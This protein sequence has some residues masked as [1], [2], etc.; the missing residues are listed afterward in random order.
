MSDGAVLFTDVVGAGLGVEIAEAIG[1]VLVA[2][3]DTVGRLADGIM[4]FAEAVAETFAGMVTASFVCTALD[5]ERALAC[6]T[7]SCIL[8]T[9]SFVITSLSSR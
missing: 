8:A 1:A 2:V 6:S 4:L 7:A 5:S 9:S 3:G